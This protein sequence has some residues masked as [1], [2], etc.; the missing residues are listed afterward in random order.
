MVDA[1]EFVRIATDIIQ[2]TSNPRI[3]LR[4]SMA[5]FGLSL[6]CC[7]LTWN[8]ISHVVPRAGRL[9]HML[10]AFYF[11]KTYESEHV[12]CNVLRVDEK[13]YRKWIW[14]FVDLLATVPDVVRIK[15]N[16]FR[17]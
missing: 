12:A 16:Q 3:L 17:F 5:S 14:I 10:W 6:T 15:L 4:R 2:P 8:L 1:I 7:E 9:K 13:T 11:L